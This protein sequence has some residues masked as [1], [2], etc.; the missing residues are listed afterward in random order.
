MDIYLDLNSW[1]DLNRGLVTHGKETLNFA[2]FRRLTKRKDINTHFSGIAFSEFALGVTPTNFDREKQFLVDIC[3]VCNGRLLS[4]PLR[5]TQLD[6][7]LRL[8]DR[9]INDDAK[10]FELVDRLLDA[11]EF[12]EVRDEIGKHNAISRIL[13]CRW[14]EKVGPAIEDLRN[15]LNAAARG[16]KVRRKDIRAKA[17]DSHDRQFLETFWQAYRSNY[18]LPGDSKFTFLDGLQKLRVFPLIYL[19]WKGYISKAVASQL[20]I[21]GNDLFDLEQMMYL[22]EPG[23]DYFVT[24]D[25]M[26]KKVADYFPN[27]PLHGKVIS[28]SE[29]LALLG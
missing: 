24:D 13:K 6:F 29:L 18:Q 23:M 15:L 28:L 8:G 9:P 12:T 26:I 17:Y 20:K 21:G 4:F 22:A 3:D 11:S 19:A 1:I 2:A 10:E 5:Y 7:S 14:E 27:L 25:G 16:D